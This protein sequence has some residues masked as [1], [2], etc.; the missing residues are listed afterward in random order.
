MMVS[1]KES[2]DWLAQ[3]R[4]KIKTDEKEVAKHLQIAIGD[5]PMS[6]ELIK[7]KYCTS[8]ISEYINDED[9]SL[10]YSNVNEIWGLY[11]KKEY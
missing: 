5:L 9:S 7:K 2:F 11:F 8:Y 6:R 1:F 3:N 4:E 10:F